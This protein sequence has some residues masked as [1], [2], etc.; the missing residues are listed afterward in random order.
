MSGE[1]LFQAFDKDSKRDF[2]EYIDSE[3]S[4]IESTYKRPGWTQWAL[5]GALSAS[6]WLLLDEFE[7]VTN[8]KIIDTLYLIL[9]ITFFQELMKSLF[10]LFE[11]KDENIL[12]HNR[13]QPS[14]TLLETKRIA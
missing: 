1:N 3:I 8:F 7:N 5:L 10:F 14:R 12:S 11:K 4:Y 9:A 6:I 13:F 2:L